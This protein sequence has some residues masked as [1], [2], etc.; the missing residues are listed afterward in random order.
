MT[1]QASYRT[2]CVIVAAVAIGNSTMTHAQPPQVAGRIQKVAIQPLPL[3]PRQPGGFLAERLGVYVTVE[4]IL[5]DGG[6]KVESNSLAVDTVNG[7][8]LEKPFLIPVRNLRL[9][10]RRRC[11][12]KG[13]ESGEMIG[14]PPAEYALTK[15]LGKDPLEFARHSPVSFSWRPYFVTL[16]VVEPQGLKTSTKWG[17]TNR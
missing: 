5:Y 15:E 12:L 10:P 7:R 8:K 2:V 11:V 4:G 3:H 9:P 13:Y 16:L 17:I 1:Q 6:G 14:I